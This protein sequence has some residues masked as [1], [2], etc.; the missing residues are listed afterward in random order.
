MYAFIDLNI[1]SIVSYAII[2]FIFW[3]VCQIIKD[4]TKLF[5]KNI[6]M[7][8]K[9]LTTPLMYAIQHPGSICPSPASSKKS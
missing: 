8:K 1:R 3:I 4:Y 7:E 6:I 9:I 2:I 5:M